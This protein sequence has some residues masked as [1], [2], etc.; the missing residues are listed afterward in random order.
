M[1]GLSLDQGWRDRS[2]TDHAAAALVCAWCGDPPESRAA[3]A[4]ALGDFPRAAVIAGGPFQCLAAGDIVGALRQ[5]RGTGDAGQTP[6]MALAEAE[7]LLAAGAVTSG[8]DI[9]SELHRAMYPAATVT[10]SRHRH[11]LGDHIGAEELAMTLPGHAQAAVT[12]AKAAIIGH[13]AGTAIRLLEPF[14]TGAAVIPDAMVAGAVAMVAASALARLGRREDL[15]RLAAGLID[16]PD[17]AHEMMP[18]VARV[19]WTA[20]RAM[21]AWERFKPELGEWSVAGRLELGL[22]S[23]DADLATRLI[24]QSGN[25]GVPSRIVLKLLNGGERQSADAQALLE[26][27]RRIHIWRTHPYRWAPWIAAAQARSAEVEIFDLAA[28]DMPAAHNL[29]H[30][31]LDDSALLELVDPIPVR[32]GTRQP[33]QDS[34]VW[35][36]TP[37]C[38]GIGIG[39]DWPMTE[40]AALEE[41]LISARAHAETP[42]TAAVF[43]VSAD[44]ALAFANQGRSMV[45]IAPPGDPFWAGPLPERAW[46]ALHVLRA[47]LQKGW[48]GAGPRAAEAAL[49]LA[50]GGPGKGTGKGC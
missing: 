27:G 30:A 24:D 3:M 29:P 32:M 33:N 43:V 17:L 28:G 37:L 26:A 25:I 21:E 15:E 41:C 39:H 40:D 47:D 9:L 46:P 2:S 50:K 18:A 35:V 7:A 10:L 45:V 13:R 16:A 19:A 38:A 4:M 11:R 31:A 20:G 34:G 5:A 42:E 6:A 44:T 48:T 23:G 8:L 22:L 49:A 1:A 14:L 12:G 36:E